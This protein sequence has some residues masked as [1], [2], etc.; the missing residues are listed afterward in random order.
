MGTV[1]AQNL[2]EFFAL[3]I[4]SKKCKKNEA[5]TTSGIYMLHRKFHF[6][7]SNDKLLENFKYYT[8]LEYN[9]KTPLFIL[10]MSQ[11]TQEHD[12]YDIGIWSRVINNKK[13]C[14]PHTK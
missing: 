10:R 2:I 9:I 1:V 12:K 8:K 3:F 13:G 11:D 5:I 7:N 4:C 14:K 6:L